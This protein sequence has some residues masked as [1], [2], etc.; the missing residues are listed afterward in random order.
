MAIV[1]IKST[2]F[3]DIRKKCLLLETL[4]TNEI[5]TT[6]VIPLNGGLVVITTDEDHDKL[7]Q[8]KTIKDLAQH[9]FQPIVPPKLKA[10][11]S[12]IVFN[13]DLHIYNNT[14]ND[15]AEE[16]Y[17]HNNWLENNIDTIFKFPHSKNIKI[18]FKQATTTTKTREVDLKLFHMRIPSHQ[19][20]QEK[21]YNIKTCFRCYKIEDHHTNACSQDSS[22]KIC[23]ECSMTGHTWRECN[24]EENKCLNCDGNHRTLS[25]K[26]ILRKEAIKN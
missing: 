26:C 6:K 9:G 17:A 15:I 19:I 25:M 18:T 4:S 8:E 14:E 3:K 5:Y 23:S 13:V 20:H 12:V 2:N 21:F 11:R 10:K 22:F 24:V 1:K 7:F 16:M